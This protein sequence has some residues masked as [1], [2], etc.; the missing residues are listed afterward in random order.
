MQKGWLTY[1]RAIL[2]GAGLEPA[3]AFFEKAWRGA[4]A[5]N[6]MYVLVESRLSLAWLAVQAGRAVEA[7]AH[8]RSARETVP[9]R[10]NPELRAG[11]D[12]VRAGL[13]HLGGDRDTAEAA[14]RVAAEFCRRYDLRTWL[15]R[16]GIGLGA[17]R[18]LGGNDA[19]AER[20]WTAAI[21]TARSMSAAKESLARI[22]IDLARSD[23]S[24]PPR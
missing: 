23:P 5:V 7:E 6:D 12:M 1:E 24:R 19:A 22:T 16:A 3:E 18:R 17:M 11:I 9:E 8:L 2:A 15:Y 4:Q 20:E 21:E 13:L 10:A 14:Y